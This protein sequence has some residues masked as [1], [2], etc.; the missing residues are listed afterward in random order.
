MSHE[1]WCIGCFSRVLKF[2][3]GFLCTLKPQKKLLETFSKNLAL[4][5][6]FLLGTSIL[7]MLNSSIV[8]V[9]FN[10]K[11]DIKFEF[12]LTAMAANVIVSCQ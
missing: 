7:C 8:S 11:I 4:L 3:S 10:S 2:V 12:C 5:S 9:K 1:E 6:S